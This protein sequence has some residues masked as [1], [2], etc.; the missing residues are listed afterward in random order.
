[1]PTKRSPPA[2]LFS[3]RPFAHSPICAIRKAAYFMKPTTT[4][5]QLAGRAVTVRELAVYEFRALLFAEEMEAKAADADA[6]TAAAT[7]FPGLV[8]DAAATVDSALAELASR[9]MQ[10]M[11]AD[12]LSERDVSMRFVLAMTTATEADLQLFTFSEIDLLSDTMKALNEP[13]F[14]RL[15]TLRSA[16]AAATSGALPEPMLAP[17]P[18]RIPSGPVR[19]P[20]PEPLHTNASAW[21][22]PLA[23][24]LEQAIQAHGPTP[25]PSSSPL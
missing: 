9:F 12:Y 11:L 15:R 19:V 21:S 6:A 22:D 23:H 8:A 13:F 20:A 4:T 18:P 17:P 7:P 16:I 24:S 14:V 1:V 5:L 25:T 3:I 10:Q 2:P